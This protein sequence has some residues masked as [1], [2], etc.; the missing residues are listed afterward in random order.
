MGQEKKEAQPGLQGQGGPGAGEGGGDS[1]PAGRPVRS[2]PGPDSSLEEGPA[3][4]GAA[5]VQPVTVRTTRPRATLPWSPGCT[6][7]DRPVEG[8]E[9]V[10]FLV[11][12][13][14]SMNPARRR[15]MVDREHDGLVDR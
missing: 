8:A 5:G 14:R 10:H 3:T 7:G 15:E 1:G 9:R 12:T 2:P 13:V 4:G 11:E 6:M